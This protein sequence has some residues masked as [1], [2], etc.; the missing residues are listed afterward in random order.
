MGTLD[1]S[2]Q[3]TEARATGEQAAAEA[4]DVSE[5]QETE[6]D[7]LQEVHSSVIWPWQVHVAAWWSSQHGVV[8]RLV[9]GCRG[10]S[11]LGRDP[12]GCSP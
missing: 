4:L 2:S 12:D 5:A 3:E 10:L 8:H 7:A 9:V 6:A 1:L 11:L